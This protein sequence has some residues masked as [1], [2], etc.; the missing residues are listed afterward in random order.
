MADRPVNMVGQFKKNNKTS[1]RKNGMRIFEGDMVTCEVKRRGD[2]KL[3]NTLQQLL[4]RCRK[5]FCNEYGK[6]KL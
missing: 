2:S 1:L 3:E 4:P 6:F 5:G